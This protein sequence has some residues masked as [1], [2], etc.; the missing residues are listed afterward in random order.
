VATPRSAPVS[1]NENTALQAPLNLKAPTFWKF[2]HLKNIFAFSNLSNVE[3][4]S[5]GVLFL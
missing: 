3:E 2:S 5:M 4:V 1:A